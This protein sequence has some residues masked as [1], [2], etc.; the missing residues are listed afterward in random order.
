M[1]SGF[2]T[3]FLEKFNSQLPGFEISV[4][5]K[6]KKSVEVYILYYLCGVE[7]CRVLQLPTKWH[8]YGNYLSMLIEH[9][10]VR[11]DE[12]LIT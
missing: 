7:I 8:Y 10:Q 9:V 3:L 2:L 5:E 12:V 1:C 4:D 6:E 11:K